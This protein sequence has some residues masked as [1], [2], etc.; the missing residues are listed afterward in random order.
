MF[1]DK[2]L[3]LMS[4]QESHLLFLQ[5]NVFGN[6]ERTTCSRFDGGHHKAY[7]S[8]DILPLAYFKGAGRPS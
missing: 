5:T 7:M 1:V 2:L 6:N 8:L 3:H 4:L